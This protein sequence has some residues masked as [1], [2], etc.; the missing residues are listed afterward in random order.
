MEGVH[1]LSQFNMVRALQGGSSREHALPFG[2][3]TERARTP[4]SGE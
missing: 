3:E 1:K 4:E 2:I